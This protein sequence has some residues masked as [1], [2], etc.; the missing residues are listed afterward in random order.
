MVKQ[1]KGLVIKSCE[2]KL[3]ED[4]HRVIVTE[5]GKTRVSQGWEGPVEISRGKIFMWDSPSVI[6]AIS[7]ATVYGE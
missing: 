6:S 3:K 2:T 5:K 7:S 1:R 4:I